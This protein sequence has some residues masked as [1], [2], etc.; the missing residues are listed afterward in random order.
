MQFALP[1]SCS[2]DPSSQSKCLSHC[3]E[4]TMQPPSRHW[5]SSPW[6][7]PGGLVAATIAN[8]THQALQTSPRNTLTSAHWS[9]IATDARFHIMHLKRQH[10]RTL[11][12][13][14]EGECRFKYWHAEDVNIQGNR[15]AL[16]E[17][18]TLRAGCS[19]A[20]PK[21][22]PR[23]KPPSRGRRTAKI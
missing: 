22:S 13:D 21:K 17:T 23:G 15:K 6:Q 9:D 10:N 8:I 7:P 14:G 4:A 12:W 18:Q 19:K 5:N 3:Q 2:S 11:I 16:R 1:Q 20:E